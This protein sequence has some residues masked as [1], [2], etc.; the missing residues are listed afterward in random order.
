MDA[1]EARFTAIEVQLKTVES[2]AKTFQFAREKEDAGAIVDLPNPL[3]PRR[4]D[5]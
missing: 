3:R 1:V 2:R 5:S 4:L